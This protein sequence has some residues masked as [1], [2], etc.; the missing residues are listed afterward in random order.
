MAKLLQHSFGRREEELSEVKCRLMEV[1]RKV[2]DTITKQGYKAEFAFTFSCYNF[3]DENDASKVCAYLRSV[4]P[5][6]ILS[7]S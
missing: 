2:N 5:F 1:A 4:L 3:S 7:L 6:N